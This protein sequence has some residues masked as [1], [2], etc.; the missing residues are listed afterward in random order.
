VSFTLCT[1]RGK[2]FASQ[3]KRHV[4]TTATPSVA[5]TSLADLESLFDMRP[6]YMNTLSQEASP[7][8]TTATSTTS[9]TTSSGSPGVSPFVMRPSYLS[10]AGSTATPTPIGGSGLSL[11]DMRPSYF[12]STASQTPSTGGLVLEAKTS[13]LFTDSENLMGERRR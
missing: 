13:S 10:S 9:S 12:G 7:T 5:M 11:L 1:G 6:A 8:P 4:A 2:P 3:V